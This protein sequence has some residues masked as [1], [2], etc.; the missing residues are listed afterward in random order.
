MTPYEWS[1]WG[2]V[3]EP[4]ILPSDRDHRW[5]PRDAG[6]GIPVRIGYCSLICMVFLPN[7]LRHAQPK[8]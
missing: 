7:D 2:K 5:M 1:L 8:D 3:T 6:P 4:R